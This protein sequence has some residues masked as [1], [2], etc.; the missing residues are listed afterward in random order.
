MTMSDINRD[1]LLVEDD[2]DFAS[3]LADYLGQ[4]GMPIVVHHRAEGIV[5]MI[6]RDSP[7]AVILDQF[8][9]GEDLVNILPQI[10]EKY[11]GPLIL[12]TGNSD[13]VDRVVCL[14]AGAD[15]FIQ[16]STAPREILARLRAVIRRA[17]ASQTVPT[18]VATEG[19]RSR[20]STL[21]RDGWELAHQTRSLTNPSGETLILT[22]AERDMLWLLMQNMGGIVSREDASRQ[23]L[24]RELDPTDR[25]VDNL[26]SRCRKR[27][28]EI[29]G[30]MQ[31]DSVR[32]LGYVLY[33]FGV[34]QPGENGIETEARH[35]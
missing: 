2:P 12:L 3:A 29:G 20:L 10:R 14:E 4:H 25:A 34:T 31:I 35:A 7:R 5:D 28:R 11:T 15:D 1:L 19:V 33:G 16:K 17:P 8:V 18:A 26:I 27:V 21:S 23:I 24:R 22:G 32:G 6:M 13:P 9:D 30:V